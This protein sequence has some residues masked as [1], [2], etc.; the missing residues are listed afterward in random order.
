MKAPTSLLAVLFILSSSSLAQTAT[1]PLKALVQETPPTQQAVPTQQAAAEGESAKPEAARPE[2]ESR[3]STPSSSPT[4]STPSAEATASSA[5]AVPAAPFASP[6]A[7]G[8]KV[9]LEPMNGFEQ[10]LSDAIVKRKVPVVVVNERAKADFVMSG[11]AHV[12]KP[13]WKGIVL[14]TRGKG[15]VSIKDARTSNVVFA[16]NF[17]KVDQGLGEYWIYQGWANGCA[18][19]LKKALEK[20]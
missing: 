10:F 4:A 11:E 7:P 9:F 6:F 2:A 15:N 3:A 14:D 5:D 19:H 20:K 16:C 18:R 13:G 12:K 17:N 1:S 8:A